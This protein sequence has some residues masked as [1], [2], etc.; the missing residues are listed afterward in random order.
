[1]GNKDKG[2]KASKKLAKKT[3]AEKRLEKQAK[4]DARAKGA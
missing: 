2:A 1:M 4:R 3:L